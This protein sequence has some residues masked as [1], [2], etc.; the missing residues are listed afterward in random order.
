MLTKKLYNLI[1]IKFS[2][3]LFEY[4][5]KNFLEKLFHSNERV[6]IERDA[7]HIYSLFSF[8]FDK[9]TFIVG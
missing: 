8:I 5:K 9:Q 1:E 4:L 7:K 3:L 6:V 2:T